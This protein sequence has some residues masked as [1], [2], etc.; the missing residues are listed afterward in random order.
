VAVLTELPEGE[1]T[2]K[3]MAPPETLQGNIEPK[4]QGNERGTSRDF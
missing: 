3:L 2:K 1:A 4:K